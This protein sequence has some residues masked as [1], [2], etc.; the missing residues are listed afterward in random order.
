[1]LAD[2]R[3]G[4]RPSVVPAAAAAS[5]TASAV[6]F[7]AS[8][9]DASLGDE[10]SSEPQE[11]SLPKPG[12]AREESSVSR[13]NRTKT[14]S[15]LMDRVNP[16]GGDMTTPGGAS[17]CGSATVSGKEQAERDRERLERRGSGRYRKTQQ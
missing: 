13:N 5:T 9:A 14:R 12:P 6:T 10:D 8:L 17:S 11:I 4:I 2:H 7:D 16:R 15:R 3:H 1:M